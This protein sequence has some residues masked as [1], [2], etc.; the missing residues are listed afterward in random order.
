MCLF[1]NGCKGIKSWAEKQKIFGLLKVKESQS[2]ESQEDSDCTRKIYQYIN[3]SHLQ[4]SI[5]R[6]GG[7]NGIYII[8]YFIYI[9]IYIKYKYKS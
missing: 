1:E 5:V 6:I 7:W 9:I 8:L 2:S 3:I 4:K